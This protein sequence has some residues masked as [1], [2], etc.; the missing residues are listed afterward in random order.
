M[1]CLLTCGAD[2]G[3]KIWLNG[4]K[5]LCSP[6][7]FPGTPDQ[8]SAEVVLEKGWNRIVVKVSQTVGGWHFIMRF[9]TK[10]GF[11]IPGLKYSPDN[12]D[13]KI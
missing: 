2:D 4:R 12:P 11:G 3:Y 6:S 10:D 5:A 9:M 13:K 7:G 1:E 8:E